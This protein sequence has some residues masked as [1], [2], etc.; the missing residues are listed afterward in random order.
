MKKDTT[1]M[2]EEFVTVCGGIPS[3]PSLPL[4][5]G[6]LTA[7]EWNRIIAAV[8]NKQTAE[9]AGLKTDEELQRYRNIWTEAEELF[10]QYGAW[11]VFDLVELEW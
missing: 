3:Y 7:R 6:D 1:P 4:M 11:P 5:E 9:E 2:E 8:N 10:A